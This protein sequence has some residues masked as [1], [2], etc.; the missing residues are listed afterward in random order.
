[1]GLEASDHPTSMSLAARIL[2]RMVLKPT[3]DPLDP[4]SRVR[5]VVET[6]AGAVEVWIYQQVVPSPRGHALAIK[7]PGAA[8]R[9]ER[10]GPHPFECWPG[11]EA[12]IWVV[13]P[14]GYG[15]SSGLATLESIPVAT[16]AIWED[17]CKRCGSS[18]PIV[19]GNSF[20]CTAALFLAAHF[21]V[22]G[23][24]LR[25]PVPLSQL[26][27][28]RHSWWNGGWL[29]RWMIKAIP[30]E[31]DAVSNATRC[32]APALFFQSAADK[33]IPPRYQNL[34]IEA[35]AG[36]KRVFA[37]HGLDHHDPL[38]DKL[39]EDYLAALAWLGDQVFRERP[40]LPRPS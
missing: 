2:D 4:E 1:M 28:A 29:A 8:G 15:G 35:Y 17:A 32:R 18:K 6:P 24:L 10:G 25:N 40:G 34:I 7:F 31:L 23:I 26:I 22:R 30:P 36:P 9:A 21:D 33:L 37:A 12:D 3:R 39:R 20:G 11:I 16:Q 27:L 38:P 14:P 13:N 19:I 5:R